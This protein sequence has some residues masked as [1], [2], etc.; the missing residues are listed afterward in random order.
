MT[1]PAI[2]LID[3]HAGYGR[4]EVL[5]GVTFT[6]PTGSLFALLGPNG[7]GKTTTLKLIDGLHQPTGGCVHIAGR[8][9]NGMAAD[10]LARAH[11]CSIPEGRGIFPNLTVE[12][13][14]RLVN[15][16]QRHLSQSDIEA[17]VFTRF[18]ILGERRKQYAGT[19]SGGQQQMLALSRAVAVDPA[20]LLV[21]E[22]SMGL[23]PL[24][25]AELY[26]TL[27]QLAAG[28]MTIL[29]VEQF[30]HAVLSMADYAAVMIHGTI[31]AMGEPAD[32]E[33]ALGAYLGGVA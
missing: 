24:V 11:V 30:A 31:R 26:D 14:L 6:V 25:V 19:L 8:H 20:L 2:E 7:A 28:G 27:G 13:N 22:L 17:R 4:I 10:K 33:D 18:P 12:E 3:V 32:V 1:A 16:S 21:D 29:I 15:L 23:A 9:V 5:H